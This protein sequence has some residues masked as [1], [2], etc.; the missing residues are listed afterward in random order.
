MMALTGT[1]TLI[2]MFGALLMTLNRYTATLKFIYKPTA[3]GWKL[4]GRER[5]TYATRMMGAIVVSLV[6]TV[7]VIFII[8]TVFCIRSQSKRY[9]RRSRSEMHLIMVTIISCPANLM[10]AL[11]DASFILNLDNSFVNWFRSQFDIY[12][13]FMM[14]VNAYSI[15]ILSQQ[16]R[17]EI[18]KRWKCGEKKSINSGKNTGNI[19]AIQ[20][21]PSIMNPGIPSSLR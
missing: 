11:Y 14:T 19:F 18:W 13:F 10:E 6:E 1:N 2:H 3:E 9:H 8:I 5:E 16:L 12:Y 21:S 20:S 7:N 4:I 15:V 17:L